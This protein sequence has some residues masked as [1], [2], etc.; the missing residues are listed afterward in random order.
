MADAIRRYIHVGDFKWQG[1]KPNRLFF[2][3]P[4]VPL[5]LRHRHWRHKD[6]TV[7]G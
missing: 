7:P 6:L 5:C 3:V 2:H 1:D 4:P